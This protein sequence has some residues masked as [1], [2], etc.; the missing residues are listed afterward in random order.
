MPFI[1]LHVYSAFSLLTSTATVEQLVRDAKA[2]GFSALALTDHNVMYGTVAFYKECLRNSIKPLLGLTVDVVS[3]SLENESFPLVL[4]AKNNEGFQNLIKISS[5][6]QTKSPE[7]IP[8]K[9]LKHYAAGLFAM[10]PG[11]R[12]EIEYYLANEEKDKALNTVASYKQ[13]FGNDN[14]YL[15]IQDH[16]L[17]GQKELVKQLAGLG[18][19]TNTP[20]AA[21]NKVHY[22]DKE[23]SFAQECLLAIKNGD[24]LQDD[25]RERLGSSEYYLKTAK[26][27]GDLFSEYPEALE[28]TLKIAE[29]CNVMLD[30]GTRH[31]PKFPVEPGKS[32]DGMLEELC[33]QGLEK[34]YGN[35]S[36]QHVER[37][38]YE[39]SIIKKMNFSDYFLIV[40]DFIK[41]SREKGIL[42]GPGRGSAAGSIVSYVLFITDADPIEHNLLFERFLNPERISMPDIDI[43]FPDNRRDEVIEY[44]AAKYGEL[45]VAQ[46][47]TFGT[48][49]AKAAVRDVGRVFGLNTKELERLSR[50]VPSRLGITLKDAINE[51]GGL[52]EF[53]EESSKNRRILETAMKLEGLPRH[54]STHAA[55][56]VISEQPLT[57]V[58]PIQSG[59]SRVF[60][61][62]YSMD[63]LEE[64]GLLK[65]DFLGL[66]NLTL[67]DSILHSIQHKTGK[68]LRVHDIPGED[69]QTFQLL[70]RGET[71]GI[72]QLES[73]GMRK[74][75]TRLEPTRFEDIVAVNALYR[76]GPM[77]NIPLF[78][79]R[80]HGRQQIDYYH[81]DL[82]P[83]LHDTYGVIV[84]QEQIMQIASKMAGFSLGEADL[85]RRA[86]S[87]K[88][89]E[90]LAQEREH[91]VNGA[92]RKGYDTQTANLVY[93]LI[94]RFANYGF[95]RSHAVAYSMIAYQLAYLKTHYPLYFMASLLT[96]AIGNDTKIAQ[97][98]RELQQM[99]IKLLPPS[100]NRS[101]FSFQ[102][103]GDSVRY[104]LAGI[105]GVGIASLKEIFQAR[106]TGHF[107]DIFDFCIRVPQ[108]A[109]TRKVVEA[110][111]YSGAFDEFGQDRAV[112]LATIDVALE[113]AQLVAPDDN[114]Q[115]DMFAEAEFSL[116]PKYIEVDP[117]RIEDKLCL[118]KEVLGVYL[119]RHPVSIHEKEF[120]AA[121]VKK[122][123]LKAPGS[124]IRLGV[125]ITEQK[126]IR[127][128]KGEA[129]AFLT[130]SDASG[131]TEAVVFPTVY[132]QYGHV[133]KQGGMALLE[134]K[135]DE[136]DG[137]SQFIVQ[138]VLDLEKEAQKNGQKKPVLY[139]RITKGADSAGKM[140]E[141]KALLKKHHGTVPVIVY[142]EENEKSMLLPNEFCVN[143]ERGS[144]GELKKI[145]GD[146]NVVLKN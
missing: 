43:D 5:A 96:S 75:L 138:Q 46:I 116:K 16:G 86:V 62:Q 25:A 67:I 70:G 61:T 136:R 68:K 14:F 29:E 7:G 94:V 63:H 44:V 99:E 108:K 30:F 58:V 145:L 60:L 107:K 117:M 129:M 76:P 140:N 83:I 47:A 123:A 10:T 3:T 141:L 143:P 135:F 118:E 54:T 95:N 78:I 109:A 91:F 28:N 80:K 132:K 88:K 114:G 23:D 21:S 97:Y 112:L 93:D 11:T 130:L 73:E 31:L 26:E 36:P 42:I 22:L 131:E 89:K 92:L 19:E 64:I 27:M 4:L 40:W 126:K 71:T 51:S 57:N 20:L 18:S 128:K 98:A 77:E 120:E 35:P 103:E 137:R 104:S 56:V 15:A 122:I 125:Y 34:R 144:V 105:K 65:M 102:P 82:E 74:V 106:R 115:I 142:N 69:K 87:K 110:L 8:V 1:H 13:I 59:Q 133:L 127:T 49:A 101:A 84:Y 6:V 17:P 48:L 90:V 9:W 37:L 45:H 66:R 113:H 85:L 81:K 72:F 38:Q 134:G 41:Y 52:R 12:G 39:L 139:L 79:D 119:S 33:F 2:K 121:G 32:A 53:I 50:L 124:K 111:I 146:K 55:G 100:I 24:K